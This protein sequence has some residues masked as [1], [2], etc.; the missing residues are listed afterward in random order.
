MQV[1][2]AAFPAA[3]RGTRRPGSRNAASRAARACALGRG[4]A[5]AAAAVTLQAARQAARRALG[6][7]RR[8][9]G[10]DGATVCLSPPTRLTATLDAAPRGTTAGSSVSAAFNAATAACDAA[11]AATCVSTAVAATGV[12]T[13]AGAVLVA[14]VAGAA[15][16]RCRDGD[17]RQLRGERRPRQLAQHAGASGRKAGKHISSGWEQGTEYV[18]S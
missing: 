15:G 17:R 13:A 16:G 4:A 14:F 9:I 12:R 3:R 5:A 18:T 7:R 6:G 8:D 1:V 10:P 11:T 2:P